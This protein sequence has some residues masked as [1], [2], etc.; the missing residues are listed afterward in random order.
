MSEQSRSNKRNEQQ[1]YEKYYTDNFVSDTKI[2]A[3]EKIMRSIAPMLSDPS[4]RLLASLGTIDDLAVCELGCGNGELTVELAREAKSI[5]A[6]D[7]S[8]NAVEKTNARIKDDI[9]LIQMDAEHLSFRNEAFD[10]VVGTGVLHHLDTRE[11]SREISRILKKGGRAFFVEPLA[12]NPLSNLWRKITPS[13][14]TTNEWPLSYTE[15]QNMG[16]NFSS[17]IYEE[18]DLLTLLTPFIYLITHS[19]KAKCKVGKILIKA[20][21]PFLKKFKPLSSVLRRLSASVLIQF[22]K[23]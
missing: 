9:D 1:F 20:E 3:V 2:G 7:L 10:L 13:Y 18:F 11:A 19:C 15:I 22:T 23:A 21:I 16:Q 8:G 5:V 14:R 4:D 17:T 12:H 6:I